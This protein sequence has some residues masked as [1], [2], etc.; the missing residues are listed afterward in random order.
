MGSF[1]L[2]L[3]NYRLALKMTPQLRIHISESILSQFRCEVTWTLKT[4]LSGIGYGW[5]EVNHTD[6]DIAYVLP[7][8]STDAK[9]KIP[10]FQSEWENLPKKLKASIKQKETGK[11]EF[12]EDIIRLAFCCL[13]GQWESQWPKNLHGFIEIPE[14]FPK[15][16][17]MSGFVSQTG[18][19]IEKTLDK[20]G[21]PLPQDI[22]PA[23]KKAAAAI[24]H[25]VDYPQM[26]RWVEPIRII[27]RL[28]KSFLRPT[29]QVAM[30]KKTHWHVPS[31]M[32]LEK[33]KGIKS[34][35]H[36]VPNQGSL[37]EYLC[38]RP[39]PFYN[40]QSNSFRSLFE[41]IQSNDFEIAMHAGYDAHKSIDEFIGQK[42]KLEATCGTSI[43]GN[44][45]HF[46]HLNPED[47]EDTL[48]MHEKVGFEYDSSLTHE[49]YMGWR[50]G[51]SWPFFPFHTKLRRQV[52]TLQ[53]STA[54]MD[55]HL[56]RYRK[57]NSGDRNVLLNE[58]VKK[59]L[60]QRGCLMIDVHDFVYDEV[61]FPGWRS[62]FES[63]LE[64]LLENSEIWVEKP[65]TIASHWTRRV[66]EL[67]NQSYGLDSG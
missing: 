26:I 35:F 34:S 49:R 43:V 29:L 5:Q 51:C 12:S 6:C 57:I 54:W 21:C 11:F 33:S 27:Q 67:E 8:T 18:I 10:H 4:L 61:L 28:G 52:N 14:E 38:A 19:L 9:I 66:R 58:L 16:T 24:T 46:W 36:F 22:W 15:D 30:G 37:L 40:I 23:G 60:L 32:A 39:D 47:P 65:S 64:R 55:E 53:M 41:E 31:W 62:T 25:D 59:V 56:F 42:E 45:H 48:L 17:L 13:T 1:C 44:R 3:R 50:R 63:L 7:D 20:A 2:V